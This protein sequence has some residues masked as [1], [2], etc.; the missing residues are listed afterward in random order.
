M[1]SPAEYPVHPV[2]NTAGKGHDLLTCD[3]EAFIMN[4]FGH[5]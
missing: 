5:F 4:I 1:I 2:Y 3:F